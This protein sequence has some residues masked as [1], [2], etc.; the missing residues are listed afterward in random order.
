LLLPCGSC[1]VVGGGQLLCF[2]ALLEELPGPVE[3]KA[4]DEWLVLLEDGDVA[5]GEELHQVSQVS[6]PHEM[7]HSLMGVAGLPHP[8]CA[9]LW[10]GVGCTR[11]S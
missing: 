2:K 1:W 3:L 5:A 7:G 10:R 6:L 8:D 11:C 4:P 9:V